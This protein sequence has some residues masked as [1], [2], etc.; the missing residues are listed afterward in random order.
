MSEKNPHVVEGFPGT[1]SLSGNEFRPSFVINA[2]NME[3]VITI[4][5][6][7]EIVVHNP[8]KVGEAAE[9]FFEAL[10]TLFR[11]NEPHVV[12]K[13]GVSE[14]MTVCMGQVDWTQ[15]A[16][17]ATQFARKADGDEAAIGQNCEVVPV[18]QAMVF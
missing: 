3:P 8:E 10:R 13:K 7:G 9:Q 17:F 6:Q 14:F 4:T 11:R 1:L 16:K 5:P 18:S 2:G 12:R 15:N